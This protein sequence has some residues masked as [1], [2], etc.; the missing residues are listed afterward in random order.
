MAGEAVGTGVGQQIGL[1]GVFVRKSSG[2]I[3]S[4][5]ALDVFIYNLGLIS[6][7]IAIAFNQYYGPA[8]YPGSNVVISTFIAGGGMLFI[9]LSF[10]MWSIIFPRSGG[11]Y[12]YQ[13]RSFGPAVAF[14][15]TFVESIVALFY[16]SF[17]AYL[18][19]TV[20]LAAGFT[21]VGLISGSTA[22]AD[23][24]TWLGSPA[25]IFIVGSLALIVFGLIPLFGMRR[26]FFFQKLM[27]V[28]AVGGLVVTLIVL[29]ITTRS[30]FSSNLQHVAGLN[31]NDVI[32]AAQQKGYQFSGY[33]TNATV[34]FMVWPL[35]AYLGGVLS[36]GIGGEIKKVSRAQFI[37]LPVA[38]VVAAVSIA[39]FSGLANRLF[40]YDFQGAIGFNFTAEPKQSTPVT[41]WVS[42]LT[43]IAANNS[44]VAALIALCFAAWT[45]FWLP[46][47]LIYPQRIMLAWSFDRLAPERV[48]YV[49]PRFH[50][51]VVAI[52][53][54]I[55]VCVAFMALIAFTT[56]GSLVLIM[57]TYVSYGAT[58]VAGVIFPWLNPKIFNSSPAARYRLGPLPLMSVVSLVGAAFLLW[59]LYL[60]WNDPIAAGHNPI[61]IG[62]LLGLWALGIIVYLVMRSLRRRQ[63]INIGLAFKEIPIE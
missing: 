44:I 45:Y 31:Y 49:H 2:L 37:G 19:T 6:V 22:L 60:L 63:G 61:A 17:S 33:T 56:Y 32:A 62:S 43:A 24:G 10:Y 47:E 34:A 52:A 27:F 59:A 39:I 36:I 30:A 41:P 58:M 13:S 1:Q 46:A 11:D 16:S 18:F 12:V 51:P 15:L 14:P 53:I 26:F 5:G 50:T 3:R 48:S 7:G 8:L 9:A 38:L 28:I 20:G 40:G 42:V 23:I 29:L 54:S 57:G 21:T 25:G 35:L 55:A 4:A